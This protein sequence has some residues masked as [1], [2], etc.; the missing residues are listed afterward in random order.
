MVWG[1]RT[2]NRCELIPLRIFQK[3]TGPAL[4]LTHGKIH[5]TEKRRN[6]PGVPAWW[7]RSQVAEWGSLSNLKRLTYSESFINACDSFD[8]SLLA[9]AHRDPLTQAPYSL[10]LMAELIKIQSTKVQISSAIPVESLSRETRLVR[11]HQRTQSSSPVPWVRPLCHGAMV[12]TRGKLTM[13]AWA[14]G[15]KPTVKNEKDS[16][17]PP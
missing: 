14:Q 17:A 7:F 11:F 2:A 10:P 5:L 6:V 9:L 1:N 3:K 13:F 8:V 15:G 4:P 16:T 12:G